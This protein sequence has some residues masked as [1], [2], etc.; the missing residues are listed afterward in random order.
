MLGLCD[1]MCVSL[2]FF[3]LQK[4]FSMIEECYHNDNPYHN[5]LHAADVCQ[6]M[7]CYMKEPLLAKHRKLEI[8]ALILL[9]RM[10]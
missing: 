9:R 5:A 3:R 7:H 4:C 6:A 8:H 1:L 2:F 10:T